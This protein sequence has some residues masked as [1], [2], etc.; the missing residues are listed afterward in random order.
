MPSTL[1]ATVSV[2]AVRAARVLT[3]ANG[4]VKGAQIP[5]LNDER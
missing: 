4:E 3:P 5:D 2:P 1:S